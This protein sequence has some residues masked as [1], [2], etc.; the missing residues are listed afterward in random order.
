MGEGA[1]RLDGVAHQRVQHVVAGRYDVSVQEQ[2]IGTGRVYLRRKPAVLFH[3]HVGVVEDRETAAGSAVVEGSG[4]FPRAD[5]GSP[6]LGVAG[7]GVVFD[8]EAAQ[9]VFEV[10][11]RLEAVYGYAMQAAKDAPAGEGVVQL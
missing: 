11:A 8:I 2:E 10:L 7:V 1:H 6:E 3:L 9:A 5:V 4:A